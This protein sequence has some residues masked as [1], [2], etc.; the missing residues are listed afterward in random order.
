MFL[1]HETT[2]RPTTLPTI[3]ALCPH[4]AIST[5]PSLMSTFLFCYTVHFF[6]RHHIT[7]LFFYPVF[8]VCLSPLFPFWLQIYYKNIKLFTLCLAQSKQ[9][10]KSPL[11][12]RINYYRTISIPCTVTYL[13]TKL[14]HRTTGKSPF[15][16]RSLYAARINQ[17]VNAV[18]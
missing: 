17:G 11:S 5:T 4:A 6:L 1:L 2:P 13:E 16:Q 14:A 9:L 10:E 18:V 7:Y 8:K 3:A 12:T 15:P